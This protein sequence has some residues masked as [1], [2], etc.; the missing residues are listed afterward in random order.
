MPR[1]KH[2]K[3]LA[4]KSVNKKD[5]AGAYSRRF[6]LAPLIALDAERI[7]SKQGVDRFSMLMLALALIF[8]DLKGILLFFEFIKPSRPPGNEFSAH[9]GEWMGLELQIHRLSMGLIHE[10]FELL[11]AFEEEV[12][13]TEMDALLRTATT[14]LQ[15]RWSDLVRVAKEKEKKNTS[16]NTF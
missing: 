13:S 1:H 4:K 7:V 3:H 2:I 9:A 12:T 15:S 11:R 6:D 8:N 10:L 16:G 14:E 5:R